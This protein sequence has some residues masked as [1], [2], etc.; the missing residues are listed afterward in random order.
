MSTEEWKGW[1]DHISREVRQVDGV[2]TE[3]LGPTRG[4]PFPTLRVSWDTDKI[5]LRSSDMHRKLLASDPAI[6]TWDYGNRNYFVI[7]PVALK[8]DEYRVIAKTVRSILAGAPKG[9]SKPAPAP[10]ATDI[11]GQW[12]V[13]I[14]FLR[15]KGKHRLFL[16]ADENKVVGTHIGTRTTGDLRG[17]IDSGKVQLS[18]VLRM[19]GSRLR[20]GFTG[21][22]D[23]DEMRGDLNLGEYPPAR[24]VARRKGARA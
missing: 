14:E 2:E 19:E 12:D 7:R 3:V 23:G 18:S 20:Y 5:G 4:G 24:W 1:Y 15:G 6:M 21:V 8:Q 10:A 11:S 16:D 9:G 17:T 22:V 13:E